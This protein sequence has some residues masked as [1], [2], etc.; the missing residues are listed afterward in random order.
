VTAGW[1]SLPDAC[2][3]YRITES[4]FRRWAREDGWRRTD[5]RPK[6][7]RLSDVQRSYDRRRSPGAR[8]ALN[9][10]TGKAAG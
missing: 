5:G 8:T 4:T 3:L 2:K 9:N 7:Y 6:L 1:I 10:S